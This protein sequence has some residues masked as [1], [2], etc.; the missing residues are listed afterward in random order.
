MKTR[1]V[2]P[3]RPR[4]TAS[5]TFAD[6]RRV[7]LLDAAT[8]VFAERGYH[9]ATIREICRRAGANIASINYHFGDKLGLYTEVL[10]RAAGA[11]GHTAARAILGAGVP[12]QQALR[13]V[14]RA[15]VEGLYGRDR[16]TVSFRLMRHELV[17]PTPALTQVVDEVV[18]PNYDRLRTTVGA[19]MGLA[20]DHET[21]RL[22]VHSIMGQ[23][24]FYPQAG[25]VLAKLWPQMKMTPQRLDQIAEHIA[26]FSL[27]YIQHA[28]ARS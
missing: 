26:D 28:G 17:R 27:S 18:R 6:R 21:T 5:P 22:C 4:Q 16:P 25:P 9:S 19:M 11:A 20:P 10:R 2:P 3:V 23:I 12:P 24:L 7:E 1:T 15:M 8:E 13:A 14:I